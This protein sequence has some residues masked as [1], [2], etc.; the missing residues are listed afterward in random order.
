MVENGSIEFDE[1]LE[2]LR[3]AASGNEDSNTSSS[4]STNN[5]T[6]KAT[7]E[8]LTSSKPPQITNASRVKTDMRLI[9]EQFDKDMDGKITKHE[10]NFVMQNLFPE[11]VITD[12]DIDEM[13]HAA[14]LDKNGFIDFDEFAN[15]FML[16]STNTAI[17]QTRYVNFQ[18][19][20]LIGKVNF[21]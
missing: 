18:I 11:E 9:F 1:F 20:P 4:K 5:Y 8:N 13:L 2:I 7:N 12:R 10:L 6:I 17:V 3:C 21:R 16:H 15:M 14:D 19:P